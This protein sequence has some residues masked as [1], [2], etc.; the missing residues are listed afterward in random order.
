MLTSLYIS[1]PQYNNKASALFS[2]LLPD[3][4]SVEIKEAKDIRIKCIEYI[5]RRNKVNFDKIDK[6]VGAQRNRLLC[7]KGTQLPKER[8]YKR[9]ECLEYKQRLCTNLGIRL[10]S[11]LEDKKLSVGLV[12]DDASFTMLPKYLLKYTDNVVVVS[13][14]SEVY[15]EVSEN[16]LNDIGAPIRLSRSLNSLFGCD[17]IIAPKP[18]SE[19]VSVK[20]NAVILTTE[21]PDLNPC[22]TVIYDYN[23]ELSDE[24]SDIKPKGLSKT[25]LASALYTLSHMYKLGSKVPSL[26]ISEN[27]VHTPLSLK[28][29]LE[30]KCDKT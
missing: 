18:I 26:C 14:E 23:V 19:N 10:L 13:S 4:I 11:M 9:F 28:V 22:S 5:N 17:L 12:D 21:K 24:F 6:L 30:N 1:T 16:L 27:K 7:A 3:K 2:R 20:D 15:R 8:G 25:Y 29:L